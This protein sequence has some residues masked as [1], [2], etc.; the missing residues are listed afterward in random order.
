M[1][2]SCSVCG[3]LL[4]LHSLIKCC[5]CLV[6]ANCIECPQHRKRHPTWNDSGNAKP[7]FH[8]LWIPQLWTHVEG[9][10]TTSPCAHT[11]SSLNVRTS[12]WYST[13]GLAQT[14]NVINLTGLQ[15]AFP[16]QS[17]L[18]WIRIWNMLR[19]IL[20]IRSL[21]ILKRNLCLTQLSVI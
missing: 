3:R 11:I 14:F 16:S 8:I 7:L 4:T 20:Q 21:A 2:L 18:D 1:A 12:I 5:Q 10:V 15:V 17:N 19:W 9:V 6:S 13:T